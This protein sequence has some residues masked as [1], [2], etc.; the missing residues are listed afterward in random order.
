MA[1]VGSLDSSQS[2]ARRRAAPRDGL[3]AQGMACGPARDALAQD[4]AGTGARHA[5]IVGHGRVGSVVAQSLRGRGIPYVVI[6]QNL[7]FAELLRG[8]GIPVVYGDAAWP[9]VVDAAQPEKARMLAIAV[10]GRSATRRIIAAARS[11]NPG[12]E[13]VVRTH[14]TEEADWL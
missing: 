8:D 7:H 5:I 11:A 6:E 9:E 12:I 1:G 10:P 14:S 3:G 13:L 4:H 2:D